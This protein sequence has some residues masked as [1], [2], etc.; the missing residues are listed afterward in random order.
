MNKPHYLLIDDDEIFS[1]MLARALTRRGLSVS[2]AHTQAQAIA[3]AAQRTPSHAVVDLKL[4][5]SSGLALIPELLAINDT[6]K[7]LMLT[8]YSS[9]ATAVEAIKLGAINY[10]PKPA[11][12]SEILGA[13]EETEQ[14]LLVAKHTDA[15][16]SVERLEWEHI[17]R[18]L[19]QNDGNISATARDLGMHRRTLQ[20]KLAKRPRQS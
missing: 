18:V 8:G 2:L 10:L 13:F 17:Q 19:Q 14:P 1:Q 6:M 15:P 12:S 11:N 9:I 16:P 7:I 5:S 3:Q 20:R 4:E